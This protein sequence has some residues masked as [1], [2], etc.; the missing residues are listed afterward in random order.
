[1]N[2]LRYPTAYAKSGLELHKY[3]RLPIKLR[4]SVAST[5]GVEPSYSSFSF[6]SMGVA[7]GLHP[8][9]PAFSRIL[10]A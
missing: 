4:Y 2:R 1:M 10:V 8:A 7:L 9:S 5:L 6:I 3:L